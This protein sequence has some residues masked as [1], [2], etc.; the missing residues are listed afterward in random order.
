MAHWKRYSL[1]FAA[2]LMAG[3]AVLFTHYMQTSR[4]SKDA[5]DEQITLVAASHFS[6]SQ[7]VDNLPGVF[8]ENAHASALKISD[9][10]G[11][12]LGAM[13]DSRRMPAQTYKAFLEA[14]SFDLQNSPFPG[15][16]LHSWESKRR[17]LRIVA[18][19][20]ERMQ[21]SEYLGRMGRDLHLH[22]LIPLYILLGLG[23]LAGYHFF[24]LGFKTP[25]ALPRFA[26]LTGKTKVRQFDKGV[27]VTA[28]PGGRTASLP[29]ANAW[30]LRPGIIAESHI[31]ETLSHLKA[32]SGAL[33]ISFCARQKAD[34][35]EQWSGVLE[36]RGAI[37]V[38]GGAMQLP[39]P[40]GT[41]QTENNWYQPSADR[42]EWYF[43][44]G[45]ETV[46]V[47]CFILRFANAD[48]AP[49]SDS[50]E[51]ISAYVRKSTRP[52]LVEHYYES[53]IIDAESG[54][55]SNPYAMFTLKEK[56]L[57]GLPLATTAIRFAEADATSTQLQKTARNAIRVMREFFTAE[58][59]PTIARG[60]EDTLLIIFAAEKTATGTALKAVTQL[61]ASYRN[62]GRRTHAGF[63]EDAAI[64][65]NPQ[66]ILKILSQLLDKSA[67]SGAIELYT[68]GK[69]ARIL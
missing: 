69:P 49:G 29:A 67:K 28:A 65:G 46:P 22:Y 48:A 41:R 43:F 31:R 16:V 42:S 18:L 62:L 13:Y 33:S 9:L 45:D 26:N 66:Q 59:A 57:S 55:Y 56:L 54:L 7:L 38:R 14:R 52:L 21:F 35:K 50:L 5:V 47:S 3:V 58:N 34:P 8:K 15:Y 24:A 39:P 44:G 32:I 17:K 10:R 40:A 11:A 53:S 51:R 36:L 12:F 4:Y 23:L 61:V 64:C 68:T 19:S 30:Q 37:L 6:L 60:A 2:W 1:I 20:L 27:R 25:M 63:I